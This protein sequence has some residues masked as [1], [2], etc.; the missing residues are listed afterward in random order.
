MPGLRLR[1][2]WMFGVVCPTAKWRVTSL[3]GN[4][5]FKKDYIRPDGTLPFPPHFVPLPPPCPHNIVD[6]DP[7]SDSRL[8]PSPA[9]SPCHT[10]AY[11]R[12]EAWST[13]SPVNPTTAPSS[14]NPSSYTAYTGEKH[15]H[16]PTP[17][18]LS[19]SQNSPL[20][21]VCRSVQLV[22]NGPQQAPGGHWWKG[23]L[24]SPPLGT[25]EKFC[26]PLPTMSTATCSA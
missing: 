16:T 3:A 20:V 15:S 23:H 24:Q 4:N 13:N 1:R 12:P 14:S 19:P 18:V 8:P 5:N 25:L 7:D 10:A 6:A 9:P 22:Y 17:H 11:S 2:W 26:L 21:H